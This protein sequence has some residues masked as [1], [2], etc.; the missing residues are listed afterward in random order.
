MTEEYKNKEWLL[1]KIT[2]DHL[3]ISEIADE[4]DV[5]ITTISRWAV[6]FDIREKRPYKGNKKGR[7]NPYW[8]GGRYKDNTWG[9]IWLYM[10]EHPN[11]NN[12]GYILEHRLVMEQV[13]GRLLDDNEIIR[14]KNKVK[15]DNQISNLELLVIST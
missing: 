2:Q 6:R 12:K 11:C 15:D 13:L 14:H 3:L 8:K 10:P 9:Y 1:I 4:C 5:S 7:N